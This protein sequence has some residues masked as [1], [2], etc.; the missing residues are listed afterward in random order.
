MHARA[1]RHG[2]GHV[3]SIGDP[4]V[5]TGCCAYGH[6]LLQRGDL[7]QPLRAKPWPCEITHP[8]YARTAEFRVRDAI[9]P[10]I[11]RAPT[12]R[13]RGSSLGLSGSPQMI[14]STAAVA[15]AAASR[16]HGSSSS[17]DTSCWCPGTRTSLCPGRPDPSTSSTRK[18]NGQPAP[19]SPARQRPPE[20]ASHGQPR[21]VSGRRP[22]KGCAAL[23]ATFTLEF[24]LML[25]QR[26][27]QLGAAGHQDVAARQRARARD[28]SQAEQQARRARRHVARSRRRIVSARGNASPELPCSC[29]RAT[30]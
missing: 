4:H 30:P 5:R 26:L 6:W 1:C 11:G 10:S 19:E 14:A 21:P 28:L 25:R 7:H 17:S 16:S 23:G 22:P 8:S 15:R 9:I 20:L 12:D 27:D 2:Q 18:V 3:L 29:P 24:E 13:A